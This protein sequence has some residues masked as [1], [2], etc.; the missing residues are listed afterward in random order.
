M[1][2]LGHDL[3]EKSISD[4]PSNRR[5]KKKEKIALDVLK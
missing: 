1:V 4:V 3:L 5:K 2:S